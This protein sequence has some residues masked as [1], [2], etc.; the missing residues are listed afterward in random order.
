MLITHYVLMI[1]IEKNP[2]KFEGNYEKVLEELEVKGFENINC[3]GNGELVLG[4]LHKEGEVKTIE[5]DGSY[6][7]SSSDEFLYNVPI[8]IEIYTR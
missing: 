3:W 1:K 7:F 6:G 8:E 5:I 2:K 4:L